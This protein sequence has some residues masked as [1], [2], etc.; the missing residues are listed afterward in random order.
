MG[1]LLTLLLFSA[2]PPTQPEL[3]VEAVGIEARCPSPE[4][5]TSALELHGIF[6]ARGAGPRWTLSYRPEAAGP[7]GALEVSLLDPQGNLRLRRSVTV[8]QSPCADVAAVFAAIVERFFVEI[9]WT[10]GTP[11][12]TT[13]AVERAPPS[14]GRARLSVGP[15]FL[16]GDTRPLRAAVDVR[17]RVAGPLVLALGT[18]VPGD[19]ASADLGNG[20]RAE[21]TGWPLRAGV[22]F[23]ADLGPRFALEAGADSLWSYETG[24]TFGAPRTGQAQRLVVD[25]GAGVV[26]SLRLGRRWWLLADAAGFRAIGSEFAVTVDGTSQRVLVIPAWR[27]VASVRLGFALWP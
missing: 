8:S 19:A 1:P 5:A 16:S 12:P 10:A 13:A 3:T 24:R 4:E 26:G 17:V 2:S 27:F 21:R 11:L 14:V 22:A 7:A 23:A 20:A 6:T 18:F 15:S 25:V 9:G